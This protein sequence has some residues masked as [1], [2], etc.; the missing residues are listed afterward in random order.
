MEFVE[1]VI[2]N[3]PA[4]DAYFQSITDAFNANLSVEE[5]R[6]NAY[7]GFSVTITF[8]LFSLF[9]VI[10]AIPALAYFL[11]RWFLRPLTLNI[12]GI[13]LSSNSFLFWYLTISALS[14]I[15][16]GIRLKYSSIR[17]KRSTP[18]I[19]RADTLSEPQMRFA[20]CYSVISEIESYRTNKRTTHMTKARE[21]WRK[22][23]SSLQQSLGMG[24]EYWF[25]PSIEIV[26]EIRGHVPPPGLTNSER[27]VFKHRF[28]PQVHGLLSKYSWFKLE[29]HTEAIIFA[30]DGLRSRVSS[31]IRA[32]KDLFQV[33]NCLL[34]L[35]LYLYTEIP[36]IA[37]TEEEKQR[38][39]DLQIVALDSFVREMSSLNEYRPES[40]R[41]PKKEKLAVKRARISNFLSAT[42][43]NPA[44]FLRFLSMWVLLQIFVAIAVSVFL[45]TIRTLRFDSTLIALLIGSP[46]AIAA[47]LTAIPPRGRVD[48]I[49]TP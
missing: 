47:A 34:P 30:F 39:A 4:L 11:T 3:K 38:L 14:A 8:F 22:L 17:Q 37:D 26:H 48:D 7:D 10:P 36:D 23:M 1:G 18:T 27:R 9:S 31:R 44:P 33:S 6:R 24:S 42:V 5:S 16:F 25:D 45:T 40:P 35:C 46:F 15:C 29:S 2:A 32:N 43:G 21:L 20:L 13:H 28:F 41:R 49:K 19:N 12:R